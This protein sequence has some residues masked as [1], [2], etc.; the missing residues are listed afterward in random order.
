MS[1]T[2]N[3]KEAS[4]AYLEHLKAIGKKS[5]T[6]GTAK[7]TLDLLVTEMGEAKEVG[8]I[9]PVH[10]DRFFKSETATMLNGKPRADASK[11]QIK[12]IIRQAL[13][14]WHEKGW[15][16]RLPLPGDEKRFV[17]PKEKKAKADKPKSTRKKKAKETTTDDSASTESTDATQESKPWTGF[18]DGDAEPA[19]PGETIASMHFDREGE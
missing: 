10:V 3:L 4:D 8:K 5:S 18:E 7:R 12:R 17:E 19:E 6:I 15:S 16:E 9:L 2:M 13:V 11:L 14:W 1:T